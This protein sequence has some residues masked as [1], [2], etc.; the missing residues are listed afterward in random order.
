MIT[1]CGFLRSNCFRRN[2]WSM[3][4]SWA[5]KTFSS[6][7]TSSPSRPSRETRT[8]T[9]LMMFQLVSTSLSMAEFSASAQTQAYQIG[10]GPRICSKRWKSGRGLRLTIQRSSLSWGCRIRISPHRSPRSSKSLQQWMHSA[11]N[12]VK[13]LARQPWMASGNFS[14]RSSKRRDWNT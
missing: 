5:R 8:S 2:S 6:S 1:W 9:D 3:W 10:I 13:W 7:R 4:I 11:E 12:M 14:S